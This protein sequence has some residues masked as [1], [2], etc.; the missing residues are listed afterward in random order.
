MNRCRSCAKV[1]L[2]EIGLFVAVC[3]VDY[4]AD[5]GA[6]PCFDMST[7]DQE[8]DRVCIVEGRIR[9]ELTF[10]LCNS[11]AV[12]I[13]D[14]N[15]QRF[16][17]NLMPAPAGLKLPRKLLQNPRD[18][19]TVDTSTCIDKLNPRRRGSQAALFHVTPYQPLLRVIL[20]KYERSRDTITHAPTPASSIPRQRDRFVLDRRIDGSGSAARVGDQ[21]VDPL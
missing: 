20:A 6:D 4:V 10:A 7:R 5:C 14:Y 19:P 1:P 9:P 8:Y 12:G 18:I 11:E 2:L 16:C 15:Q 3:F 17:A 21:R 13:H